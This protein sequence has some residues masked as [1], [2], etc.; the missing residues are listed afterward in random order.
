MQCLLHR[1][2]KLVATTTMSTMLTTLLM[3]RITI[4][5]MPAGIVPVVL[6]YQ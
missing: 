4:A 3:I 1:L 6:L 5:M 2:S